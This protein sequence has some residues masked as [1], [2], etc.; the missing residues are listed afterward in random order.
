[1]E[2]LINKYIGEVRK[3]S[4]Y[5]YKNPNDTIRIRLTKKTGWWD[6]DVYEKSKGGYSY[7]YSV[8][9]GDIFSTKKEALS[10]ATRRFGN[11]KSINIDPI[12][13]GW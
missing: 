6:Y 2:N 4:D 8:E 3:H 12:N 13:K 10:D 9:A 1:M 11:L 5:L 7:T